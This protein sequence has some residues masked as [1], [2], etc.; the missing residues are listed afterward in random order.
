MDGDLAPLSGIVKL[1]DQY[2]AWLMVDEAHATGLYGEGGAGL[3]RARGLQ[4]GVEIQMGTLSKAVG[5][6][7][8]YI[9]GIKP[10]VELLVNRARSFIF[11]TAPMPSAAAAATAGLG[12]IRG[13]EGDLRRKKLWELVAAFSSELGLE[14]WPSAVIP[15]MAGDEARALAWAAELK[16]QGFLIPRRALSQCP[17][18]QARLRATVSA[19]RTRKTSSPASPASCVR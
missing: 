14:S 7:G 19:K 11:S 10:L 8:G 2:G 1:K 12:L 3:L 4:A 6:S 15:I 5:A 18:G 13:A 16:D 9:C 17:R